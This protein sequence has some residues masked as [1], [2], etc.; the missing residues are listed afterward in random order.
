M[1]KGSSVYYIQPDHL[2]TPRIIKDSSGVLVWKWDSDL[3]G[4]GLANQ[5]P[6]G[7]SLFEFNIRFPGQVFDSETGLHYNMARYYD[8]EVG[9]YTGSDPIGLGGGVNTYEYVAGNPT[10]AVDPLG[11]E[12]PQGAIEFAKYLKTILPDISMSAAPINKKCALKYLRDRYGETGTDILLEVSLMS[13]L[14]PD[15]VNLY[16]KGAL[17]AWGISVG[18][19][20]A[21]GLFLGG[22]SLGSR[23]ALNVELTS[24]FLGPRVL[25]GLTGEGIIY[26]VK[27]AGPS[28]A[29]LAYT[30][31]T[32]STAQALKYSENKNDDCTCNYNNN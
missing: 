20:V 10:G 6:G 12:P 32:L 22:I 30:V 5:N 24:S 28:V 3:Y 14:T 9:R 27:K 19:G 31:G 23:H 21:K 11:L 7:V 25:T 26:L 13:L 16:E 17:A 18:A 1:L 8:P 2:N 15:S 29:L 4:K